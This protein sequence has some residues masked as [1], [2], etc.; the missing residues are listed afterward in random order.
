MLQHTSIIKTVTEMFGLAGPL[1]RRDASAAS[2]AD[3]FQQLQQPA[4]V[5]YA[6]AFGPPPLEDVTE[7]VVAGIRMDPS[8]EPLDEL[9]EDWAKAMALHIRGPVAIESVPEAVPDLQ[10]QGEAADFIEAR[11]KAAGL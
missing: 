9:T 11:L 5:R 10:T 1:N 2:F 7:S 6:S 8:S 4:G 3:V